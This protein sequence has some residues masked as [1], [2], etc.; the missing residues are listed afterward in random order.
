MRRL[1]TAITLIALLWL[2]SCAREPDRT[3]ELRVL[4]E[5]P[6]VI[7]RTDEL[8]LARFGMF[9]SALLTPVT[10]KIDGSFLTYTFPDEYPDNATIEILFE[11]IGLVTMSLEESPDAVPII[12]SYDIESF[13]SRRDDSGNELFY[14]QLTPAAGELMLRTSVDNIGKRMVMKVDDVVLMDATIRGAFSRQFQVV[15]SDIENVG[16]VYA[17]IRFGPLPAPVELVSF[18][19]SAQQ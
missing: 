9:N 5:D 11:S 16:A 2:S 13:E 6:E 12:T 1:A 17:V 7:A 19:D 8:L 18:R 4:S 3:F 14:V 15:G 10:S